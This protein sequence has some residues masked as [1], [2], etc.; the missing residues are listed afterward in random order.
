MALYGKLFQVTFTGVM[1][2]MLAAAAAA[3]AK[4][5]CLN[6]CGDVEIPFPFGLTGDCSL[7]P[8]FLV[9]CVDSSKPKWNDYFHVTSISIDA[10]QLEAQHFVASD[11]YDRFG[12]KLPPPPY[13]KPW[14]HTGGVFTLS[15]T[16][17]KFTALGCD[18][19]A[20]ITGLRNGENY[21][22]GCVSVCNSLHNV[23]NGSC[24]GIGCC[25][26]EIP[27]GVTGIEMVVG[28]YQNHTKI[29]NF[30][31]CGYAFVVKQGKFKFSS[32]YLS[33]LPFEVL[34]MVLDWAVANDTCEEGRQKSNFACQGNYSECFDLDTG[35]GYRCK[36]RQG[37]Q[38]NPYLPDGCQGIDFESYLCHLFSPFWCI[39]TLLI[40]LLS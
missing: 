37:Y 3:Q 40:V 1:F 31:P 17:N 22:S 13:N 28:S 18:T 6:I 20:N 10:H 32:D 5:G 30:N 19:Y 12:A 4:P 8:T 26:L 23:V 14:L 7:N 27:D 39:C 34:P 29:W 25:E 36:C 21:T 15:K 16:R 11:C 24:S 38:G 2:A 35:P 9:T 33:N